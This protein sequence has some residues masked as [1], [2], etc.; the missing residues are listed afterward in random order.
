[1]TLTIPINWKKY[2]WFIL[3]PVFFLLIIL[4]APLPKPLFNA[5][6]ATVLESSEGELLGATI[7]P[8][9]QWRFPQLDS[10]PNKFETALLL[11]EDEHF[12]L[13]PGINPFSIF[14]AIKQNLSAGKVVS[15]GSTLSMQVIRMARGNQSRTFYHKT[16]EMFL[17]LKLEL[18][19]SKKEILQQYAS[20]AP[21]GGNVVGLSAASWRYFKRPPAKLSWAEAASLAVLPNEPSSIYP[22]KNNDR[23]YEKRNK[24]LD[25]I[26]EHNHFDSATLVLYKAESLPGRPAPMPNLASHLLQR[27][28]K[29]GRLGTTIKSSLK[30]SLQKKIQS[31]TNRYSEILSQSEIYNAATIILEVSTGKTLAYVGNTSNGNENHGQYV[32]IIQAKRSPGSLLKPFLYALSLDNG[33]ILPDELIPDIPLFYKGF[34]PQNFDKK[35][36][37]A[38]KA[39]EA[40]AKSLN[41]PFVYLLRQYGYQKF[42]QKIKNIGLKSLTKPAHHYGLSLILGGSEASLW[43]LTSMYAS[44]S[45]T[46][47]HQN[48]SSEIQNDY[49]P[50]SYLQND[51]NISSNPDLSQEIRP[52]AAWYTLKALKALNRPEGY[53]QWQSSK[54]SNDISWKT[55]TSY[56]FKDAWAIGTNG[57][58]VVGVWVGNAD[59]EGRPE[60][61]G[62]K[63][64]APLLFDLFSELKDRKRIQKSNQ[65]ARILCQKS[66]L[67]ATKSCEETY[68]LELP[69]YMINGKTCIY[70]QHIFLNNSESKQVNSSCYQ[71]NKMKR[72]KWFIL[73]AVQAWYYKFYH[74]LYLDPPKF[75]AD[76]NSTQKSDFMELI[77][78]KKNTKV[79]IPKELD[80]SEGKTIFEA[81]HRKP[82]TTIYWHLDNEYLG[83]TNQIHQLGIN[84]GAGIHKITLIDQDGNSLDQN[85]EVISK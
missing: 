33:T 1:M 65:P 50:N 19:Y 7:A 68:E 63:A 58:Y 14:R 83:K 18:L 61:T 55:G 79:Y 11:F 46:V 60:L 45:R 49:F 36:H 4:F 23:Y 30:Y 80:G 43:E 74:P 6:Y 37:G 59:G 69:K 64:A 47:N 28:I 54:S 40:L 76:C 39:K 16:L 81:A 51:T 42:H 12:Y 85:F 2:R 82:S 27:A 71:V 62:V 78:P 32:D 5:S 24:L 41:V 25:K 75:L 31:K 72:K 10:V 20:H 77:Y 29:D 22:G 26:H 66:G 44:L 3:P 57:K 56:G 70:H 52:E 48:K 9:G 13:H 84:T 38:V 17:A 67:I 53:Q 21:F 35:F 8:D 73:P 15:G 34:A